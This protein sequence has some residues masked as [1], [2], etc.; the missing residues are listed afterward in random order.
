MYVCRYTL[1]EFDCGGRDILEKFNSWGRGFKFLPLLP[2][3]TFKWESPDMHSS[4]STCVSGDRVVLLTTI[5]VH[6]VYFLL[7]AISAAFLQTPTFSR[8]ILLLLVPLNAW[9]EIKQEQSLG[10]MAM[11]MFILLTVIGLYQFVNP[12]DPT[13]GYNHCK[14]EHSYFITG[15]KDLHSIS[16]YSSI[17]CWFMDQ[18]L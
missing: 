10:F 16:V 11:T 12:L 14:I 13:Y 3:H 7:A 4:I 15:A 9:S 5:V 6:I 2:L 18:V 17:K 8:A 1:I